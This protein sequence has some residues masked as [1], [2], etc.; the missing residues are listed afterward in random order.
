MKDITGN[1]ESGLGALDLDGEFNP[2]QH[3]QDCCWFVNTLQGFLSSP[4]LCSGAFWLSMV[5]VALKF[6]FPLVARLW[7]LTEMILK[8]R[9]DGFLG[10]EMQDFL[11]LEICFQW[12]KMRLDS[13]PCP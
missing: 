11:V 5:C 2:D 8:P 1:E 4:R 12:I 10:D 7:E 13:H 9:S 6:A 3:D